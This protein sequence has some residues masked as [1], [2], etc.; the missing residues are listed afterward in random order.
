M[1]NIIL[2]F[3]RKQNIRITEILFWTEQKELISTSGLQVCLNFFINIPETKHSKTYFSIIF[4]FSFIYNFKN[5]N[6]YI[7]DVLC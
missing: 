5:N 2:N 1:K 3:I 6:I 7:V 4:L